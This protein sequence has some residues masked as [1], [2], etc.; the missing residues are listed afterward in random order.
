[1]ELEKPHTAETLPGPRP[2]S[3]WVSGGILRV[4]GPPQNTYS[5]SVLMAP[6]PQGL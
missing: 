2:G 3:S 5:V 1:M 4:Q 6:I